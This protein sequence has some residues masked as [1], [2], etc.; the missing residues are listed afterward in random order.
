MSHQ[1]ISLFKKTSWLKKYLLFKYSNLEKL[2]NTINNGL[3]FLENILHK[4]WN[5]N[6]DFLILFFAFIYL[7]EHRSIN[8]IKVKTSFSD[9][10]H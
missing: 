8:E 7:C 1:L 5:I 3:G 10:G 4:F 9:I 2:K 6:Y